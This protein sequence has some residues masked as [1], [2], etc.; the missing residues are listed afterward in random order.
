MIAGNNDGSSIST[1]KL[2]HPIVASEVRI[3]PVRWVGVLAVQ[4]DLGL[5]KF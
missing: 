5:L 4:I 1:L 3:Y 2:Y